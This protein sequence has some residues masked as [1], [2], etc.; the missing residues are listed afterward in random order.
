M[1]VF[2]Y[3]KQMAEAKEASAAKAETPATVRLR[4]PVGH[5]QV[6][7]AS[8]RMVHTGPDRTIELPPKDAG[9]T[10]PTVPASNVKPSAHS[11]T[12]SISLCPKAGSGAL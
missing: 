4:A 5:G 3:Y 2:E 12:E 10:P 9:P 8:G 7:T 1:G 6:W 11:R